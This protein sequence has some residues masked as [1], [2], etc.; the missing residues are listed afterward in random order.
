MR[1][2]KME[3]D[4]AIDIERASTCLYLGL[5]SFR[6]CLLVVFFSSFKR[7]NIYCFCLNNILGCC[8]CIGQKEKKQQQTPIF[9]KENLVLI[10]TLFCCSVLLFFDC[11]PHVSLHILIYSKWYYVTGIAATAEKTE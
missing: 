5:I 2:S 6:C 4:S 3:N 10:F 7:P 11:T 9:L 1:Q 8:C